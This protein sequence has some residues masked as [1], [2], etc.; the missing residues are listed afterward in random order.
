MVVRKTCPRKPAAVRVTTFL[1]VIVCGLSVPPGVVCAKAPLGKQWPA[2]Q[3]IS[4]DKISHDRFDSLLKKYV[5]IDGYV[6]YT[7][8]KASSSDREELKKYL[9]DLSRASLSTP[10]TKNGQLAFWINA[11]NAVTLE[12]MMQVYPTTS[13]RN[14]TA[15]VFGYNIWKNLPLKV[16]DKEYSLEQIEHSILRKMKEPRIHFAIVCASVGCPKLRNEAY[17]GSKLEAQLTSNSKDFFSRSKNLRI[18]SS[19]GR[20]YLSEILDWFGEDFGSSQSSQLAT[21]KPYLPANAMTLIEKE[22]VKIS[23]LQYDW[24]IND[25][26]SKRE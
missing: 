21:L 12:G 10:S 13:I 6:N 14:H 7:D 23:Y 4:M 24:S 26:K 16:G 20:L 1:A 15:K 2:S 17:T 25:Q 3:Q 9:G 19:S 5:D 8:W 22:R 18:D 11:Y